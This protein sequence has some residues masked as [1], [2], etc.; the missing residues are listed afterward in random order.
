MIME[1]RNIQHPT[2]DD[3]E[4]WEEEK[5]NRRWYNAEIESMQIA[6]RTKQTNYKAIPKHQGEEIM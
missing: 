6:T 2:Y 1:H 3:K 5:E 4:G